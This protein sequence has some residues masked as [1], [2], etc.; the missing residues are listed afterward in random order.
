MKLRGWVNYTSTKESD[1]QWK[2]LFPLI[3][4]STR[5]L[6]NRDLRE[7]HTPRLGR[8]GVLLPFA[9]FSPWIRW[10][11]MGGHFWSSLKDDR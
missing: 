6:L 1:S 3:F 2:N 8:L 7:L 9:N 4:F 11:A 5:A 10:V